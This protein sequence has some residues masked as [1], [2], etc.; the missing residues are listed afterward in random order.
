[1]NCIHHSMMVYR[2]RRQSNYDWEQIPRH[3]SFVCHA[4]DF[5]NKRCD[6][7]WAS[8]FRA[9]F[10]QWCAQRIDVICSTMRSI[11]MNFPISL[12]GNQPPVMR[13][14]LIHLIVRSC[15]THASIG[16]V[17]SKWK[18]ERTYSDRLVKDRSFQFAHRTLRIHRI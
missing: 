16:R 7:L 5:S 10:P 14:H 6:Q 11:E 9:Q 2:M 18:N 12:T 4:K 15:S 3:K 8:M 13:L 17:Y 1:M